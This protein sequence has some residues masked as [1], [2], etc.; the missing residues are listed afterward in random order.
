MFIVLLT[1]SIPSHLRGYISRFL[2]EVQ[3]NVFV[4]NCSR[5]VSQQLWTDVCG[6]VRSGRATLIRSRNDV[7]QGYELSVYGEGA[8]TVVSLDGLELIARPT[9]SQNGVVV[10]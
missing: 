6:A 7:E 9:L 1:P 10:E 5:K 3:A 2:V 4:G 8:P